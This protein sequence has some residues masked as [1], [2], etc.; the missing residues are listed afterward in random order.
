MQHDTAKY[1]QKAGAPLIRDYCNLALYRA[2]EEG[3]YFDYLKNWLRRN[4]KEMVRLKPF[5]PNKLRYEK[6][7]YTLSSDESS[8]LMIEIFGVIAERRSIEGIM[9]LLDVL[10][11]TDPLNRS[12]LAGI[13]LKATE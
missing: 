11:D 12:P 13:L 3:P 7:Q 10:K 1:A 5:L 9:L 8:R 6:S 2:G 4:K